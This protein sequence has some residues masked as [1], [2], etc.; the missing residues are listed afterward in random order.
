MMDQTFL[1]L[2][3]GKAVTRVSDDSKETRSRPL[4]YLLKL[5]PE[6]K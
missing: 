1:L 4:E 2:G 3:W 5:R 6:N